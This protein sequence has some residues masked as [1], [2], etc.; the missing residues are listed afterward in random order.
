MHTDTLKEWI[1]T[2]EKGKFL[3]KMVASKALKKIS[4]STP[5]VLVPYYPAFLKILSDKNVKVAWATFFML[6]PMAVFKPEMAF[7][8]L[9]KVLKAGGSSLKNVV[10]VTI[11]LRDMKNFEKIVELRGKYFTPPYPADTIF[12]VSSLFSPDALIEIEAIAVADALAD[13]EK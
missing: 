11:M 4:E 3:E 8:N 1:N 6:T 12:E 5:E 2:L 7:E 13:W 9:D 10:K